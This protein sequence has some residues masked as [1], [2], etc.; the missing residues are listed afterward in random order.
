MCTLM[1]KDVL[2]DILA[3]A[4][5]YVG[6]RENEGEMSPS[7]F[8]YQCNTYSSPTFFMFV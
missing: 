8:L 6:Y 3:E 4:I 7:Q 1:E 5:A 2:I